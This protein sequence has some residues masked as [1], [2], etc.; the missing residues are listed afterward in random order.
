MIAPP[1]LPI[2]TD[3]LVLRSA[4]DDDVDAVLAYCG[5]HEVTRY[6]PFGPMDRAAVAARLGRW[7]DAL[8]AGPEADVDADWPLTLLA[9]HRGQVIGDVMLRFAPD[10]GAR[11][12]AELGY[13]FH[14]GAGGRGLATE[15]ARTMV[16]L[17]FGPGGCHRVF[18]RLDPRN[19]ASARL[20]ERLGM[21]REAH[22]RRDFWDD[23][24]WSDTAI[25]GVLRAE[26]AT[27][28]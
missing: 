2:A 14:P 24:E 27:A 5:D 22:L 23:G 1:P 12:M 3:R 7:R 8:A 6:L 10:G 26:W 15:A 16:D 11:S 13:V 9:E 17:A 20:C 25:Y 28:R 19:S 21:T 18:A 4:T